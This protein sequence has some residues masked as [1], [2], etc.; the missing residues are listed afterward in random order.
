MTLEKL[1][2]PLELC[3][4]IPEN[5]FLDAAFCWH[6]TEVAGFVCRTSG[7]EQFSGKQWMLERSNSSKITRYRQRGDQIFPAPTLEEIIKNLSE[8]FNLVDCIKN[9]RGWE[10]D[11]MIGIDNPNAFDEKSGA[12]AALK[13]W[14]E[15]NKKGN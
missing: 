4:K 6:Y 10:I 13:L 14:L 3:E 8:G 5:E 1:V 7:C 15:L 2:P 12:T 11:C 9:F